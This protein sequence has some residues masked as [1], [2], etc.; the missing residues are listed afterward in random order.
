MKFGFAFK[1]MKSNLLVLSVDQ[2]KSDMNI[3]HPSC[4]T[5]VIF[6]SRCIFKLYVQIKCHI[7]ILRIHSIGINSS[8][9]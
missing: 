5:E 8:F 7:N 1:L 6:I 4:F 3:L 9:H 2:K